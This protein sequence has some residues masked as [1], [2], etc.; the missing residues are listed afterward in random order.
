MIKRR[1]FL[2]ISLAMLI[3]SCATS[4]Q[5]PLPRKQISSPAPQG[6]PGQTS[7]KNVFKIAS[8][9]V[10]VVEALDEKGTVV[11]MGSGVAVSS[12]DVVSNH[13]VIADAKR[14]RVRQGGKTWE[15]NFTH[16]DITHDL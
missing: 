4:A 13:H 2:F 16:D 12:D 9:S 11:A 10:F 14:W 6:F 7:A 15:A 3:L 8:S 1:A 5:Q